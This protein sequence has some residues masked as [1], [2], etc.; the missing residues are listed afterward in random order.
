M[1]K[2]T[3]HNVVKIWQDGAFCECLH[4]YCFATI[5][6]YTK[7]KRAIWT[8]QREFTLV[9]ESNIKSIERGNL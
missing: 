9:D 4:V 3:F 5:Y 1:I 8:S 6:E 7:G 2:V